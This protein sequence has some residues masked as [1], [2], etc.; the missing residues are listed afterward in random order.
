MSTST[1]MPV[2]QPVEGQVHSASL[3]HL[4]AA[5]RDAQEA[6]AR[7]AEDAGPEE[8]PMLVAFRD[9]HARHDRELVSEIAGHGHD[10]DDQGFFSSLFDDGI[11]RLRDMF[12]GVHHGDTR[13]ILD[14]ERKV[15][16]AYNAAIDN[17]GPD[18]VIGLL[19]RQMEELDVLLT[20]HD[21]ESSGRG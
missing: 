5:V 2:I 7:F 19:Q 15:F 9:L 4:H 14:H 11:G 16:D 12:R 6:N 1:I 20:R 3:A 17:G 10:P 8:R 18:D 13:E 21:P